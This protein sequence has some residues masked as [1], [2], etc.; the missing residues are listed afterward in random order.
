MAYDYGSNGS[1]NGI[2]IPVGFERHGGSPFDGHETTNVIV[3]NRLGDY[4]AATNQQRNKIYNRNINLKAI[5]PAGVTPTFVLGGVGDADAHCLTQVAAKFINNDYATVDLTA[6]Y[7]DEGDDHIGGSFNFVVPS[8]GYGIIA[9]PV[10]DGAILD[11]IVAMDFTAAVQHVDKQ[12]RLGD[13]LVGFSFGCRVDAQITLVHNGTMPT[14]ATGWFQDGVAVNDQNVEAVVAVIR[15][16][17][18]IAPNA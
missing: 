5:N 18:F 1:V 4:I 3:Q 7:H 9:C 8:C 17:T 12:N 2:T 6:H 11:N 15:A 10:F 14:I 16:H 13:H